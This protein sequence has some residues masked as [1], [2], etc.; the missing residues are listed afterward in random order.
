MNIITWIRL[1]ANTSIDEMP[2][3]IKAYDPSITTNSEYSIYSDLF[4]KHYTGLNHRRLI[5]LM[6]FMNKK[7]NELPPVSA[8]EQAMTKIRSEIKKKIGYD[9][10]AYRGSLGYIVFDRATKSKNIE[11]YNKK[12][13][14][15]NRN[16][17]EISISTINKLFAENEA[18]TFQQML[19]YLLINSGSRY[20]EIYNGKFS[21]AGDG[22][23]FLSNISKTRDK[24]KKI[25]KELLDKNSEKF[26]RV[27]KEYRELE[28]PIEAGL[29]QLN[30][31]LNDKYNFSSYTLRKYYANVSYWLQQDKS[32][33]KTAYLA[34]VLG[35]NGDD[36]AK[37]YSSFYIKED[38]KVAFR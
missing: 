8:T 15:E 21:D 3:L 1:H 22:C 30:S 35:H 27:L 38:E 31:Y 23:V 10:K 13:E 14:H 4:R 16:S 18:T 2:S 24:N 34:D 5:E 37:V 17:E 32:I 26:L 33:Q 25:K 19:T 11:D 9:S 20:N 7:L 12:I 6:K 36:V 29:I 28:K